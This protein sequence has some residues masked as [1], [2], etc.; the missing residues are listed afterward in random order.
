MEG[1]GFGTGQGLPQGM[2]PFNSMGLVPGAGLTPQ[3][4]SA[5][6]FQSPQTGNP[7]LEQLI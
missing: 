3:Q 1:L 7:L 2:F 5:Y 6:P 4:L